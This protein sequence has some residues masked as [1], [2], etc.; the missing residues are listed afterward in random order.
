MWSTACNVTIITIISKTNTKTIIHFIQS[1]SIVLF[2]V[3]WSQRFS[4]YLKMMFV[5]SLPPLF[6]GGLMSYLRYLCLFT[7]SGVVFLFW[8]SSSMLAVF[9][10]CP[11]L[12][13]TLV[14]SNV[15]WLPNLLIWSVSDDGYSRNPLCTLDWMPIF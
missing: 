10:G 4:N 5:S 3:S 2:W 6:V 15:Y 1:V 13:A 8:F 11:F 7:Y 12:I 9:L 14:F